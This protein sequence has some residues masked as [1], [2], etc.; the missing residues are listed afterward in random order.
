MKT[1]ANCSACDTKAAAD[2][3]RKAESFDLVVL[4]RGQTLLVL[5]FT[6]RANQD[7]KVTS[8]DAGAD[9]YLVK[10]IDIDELPA[11]IDGAHRPTRQRP[12]TRSDARLRQDRASRRP[13]SRFPS[14]N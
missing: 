13:T 10:T 1:P 14:A 5:A 6:A 11:R 9:N 3:A 7:D 4:G 12:P 2:S 8:L